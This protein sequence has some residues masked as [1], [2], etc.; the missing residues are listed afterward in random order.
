MS[1]AIPALALSCSLALSPMARADD[2]APGAPPAAAPALAAQP[3]APAQPAG[4]AAPDAAAPAPE[5]AAPTRPGLPRFG[6]ALGG[7]FPE[8]ATAS[9]LYRPFRFLRLSAGPTWDYA[10]W[11]GNVGVT[12]V[13]VNWW[14]TPLL[15]VEAGHYLR[16][17]YSRLV[18][19][20]SADVEQVKSLLRRVDYSYAAADIGLEV[21]SPRG[22]AFTL[23]F[24]LS[25]VWITANGTGTKSTDGGTTVSF[26]DPA[27]RATLPSVKLGFQYWF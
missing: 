27:L 25:W 19:S 9:F 11:G 8:F 2:P 13:P 17:D 26:T 4:A 15:G 3:A 7:G 12:L 20:N 23:K 14:I 6:V 18:H 21:G 10:G 24:G 16:S 22:F 5:D 1:P